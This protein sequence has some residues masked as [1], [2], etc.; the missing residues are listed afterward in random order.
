MS[1]ATTRGSARSV[2]LLFIVAVA[3]GVVGG[4]IAGAIVGPRSAPGPASGPGAE[5]EPTSLLEPAPDSS[6]LGAPRTEEPT[7]E[8][9][10]PYAGFRVAGFRLLDQ[11]GESVDETIFEGEVTAL[12]F[13][14]TSCNGPCP[15]MTRAMRTIQD[16]T[17]DDPVGKNLRL[18]S[19]SVDGS[20]D[21][22]A[23]VRSF[24]E[25]Y[26]ADFTRWTFMTGSPDLVRGLARESIGFE[27]REQ[28]DVQV[29]G[30]TGAMMNNILHPTRILLVGPDRRLIGVY[31]YNDDEQIEKL[32]SDARNALG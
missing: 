15:D 7:P 8:D 17:A 12:T 2:L 10:N 24:A 14:F 25:S 20:R 13:F 11:N 3:A 5:D 28:D 19:I 9:D 6:P 16:A 4:L 29:E 32:I 26:G 23:V 22:P 21:T 18:A 31:W 1:H 30:P 27:L